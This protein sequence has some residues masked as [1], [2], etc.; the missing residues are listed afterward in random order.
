MRVAAC[1]P[2]SA[3]AINQR[4]IRDQP[5]RVFSAL[6]EAN[7]SC[8]VTEGRY[9]SHR[10]RRGQ[11]EVVLSAM[12]ADDAQRG[13]PRDVWARFAAPAWRV[14]C[15]KC[16]E[17]WRRLQPRMSTQLRAHWVEC[18]NACSSLLK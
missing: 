4:R 11:K 3:V 6:C 10:Y 16:F 9:L 5:T 13:F 12:R 18:C 15:V 7:Q 8:I 17:L 1:S 14:Q 2:A